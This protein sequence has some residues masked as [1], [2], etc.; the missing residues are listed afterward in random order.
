MSHAQPS[1]S[2]GAFLGEGAPLLLRLF[3]RSADFFFYVMRGLVWPK[4]ELGIRLWLAELFFVSG[5]LKLTHWQTALDLA[6]NEYPVSWMNPVTAAYTGVSI[7][8]IGGA[9]LAVGFMTRYAA[10]ATHPRS[11]VCAGRRSIAR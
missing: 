6:A 8:V 1:A 4:I 11:F 3:S 5:V 10:I 2:T 9:L 7:E